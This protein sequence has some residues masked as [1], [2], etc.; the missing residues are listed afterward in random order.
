MPDETHGQIGYL[1]YARSTGGKT[2]DGRDMPT[3]DAL[4]FNIRMA[5]CDAANAIR[6]ALVQSE[7]KP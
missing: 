6:V 2:Y 5:W 3:W 4:P 1:A 7:D